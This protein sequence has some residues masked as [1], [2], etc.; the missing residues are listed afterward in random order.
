MRILGIPVPSSIRSSNWRV[1]KRAC[2]L[3]VVLPLVLATTGCQL[4]AA[5]VV[6]AVFLP[7]AG[8][9][10]AVRGGGNGTEYSHYPADARIQKSQPIGMLE[11]YGPFLA[12]L[13]FVG[14]GGH[15]YVNTTAYQAKFG[16][17][18]I[19]TTSA[20]DDGVIS[21]TRLTQ[22]V[23]SNLGGECNDVREFNPP[24]TMRVQD[25]YL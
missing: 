19:A 12:G 11:Q 1:R 16:S 22:C 23:G 14:E 13:L 2:V 24:I 15:L 10:K 20:C 5:P 3:P 7:A 25:I 21:F 4:V 17:Y 6:G 9:A 18:I 8:V